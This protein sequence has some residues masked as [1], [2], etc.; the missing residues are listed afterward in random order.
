MADNSIVSAVA[1]S[2]SENPFASAWQ[3][4]T[5]VGNPH[6]VGDGTPFSIW[7]WFPEMRL[8]WDQKPTEPE[9]P[10][11]EKDEEEKLVRESE[12]GAGGGDGVGSPGLD[13]RDPEFW[14]VDALNGTKKAGGWLDVPGKTM[15]SELM[16][17]LSGFNGM[18]GGL[19]SSL[20]SGNLSTFASPGGQ[21]A[22][23]AAA[24]AFGV[25][26]AVAKNEIASA[27]GFTSGTAKTGLGST[28]LGAAAGALTGGLP[29]LLGGLLGGTTSGVSGYKGPNVMG[30]M[31]GKIAGYPNT[32]DNP[33]F[34]NIV[35]ERQT[36][37]GVMNALATPELS[38]GSWGKGT[39]GWGSPS[40][41]NDFTGMMAALGLDIT[42]D[43]TPM[44]QI[45]VQDL[46]DQYAGPKGLFDATTFNDKTK[47]LVAAIMRDRNDPMAETVAKGL[48][49][50]N[51]QAGRLAAKA[52]GGIKNI[53]ANPNL[54]DL[55]A[56][57]KA[58][59]ERGDYSG[60]A[61]NNWGEPFS[62]TPP[63]GYT[64]T[65]DNFGARAFAADIP[66]PT[67]G[68]T[69][70]SLADVFSRGLAE[71]AEREKSVGDPND[72]GGGSK[73]GNGQENESPG[74]GQS[75][76]GPGGA[77]EGASRDGR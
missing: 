1:A 2:L 57:L 44:Q 71:L 69:A 76:T 9:E 54:V 33:T 46:I 6:Y 55:Y 52:L 43:L 30:M 63:G 67:F 23:E 41:I 32:W 16:N 38:W 50:E 19:L 45:A 74:Q 62:S 4:N 3:R 58:Q 73:T 22:I 42:G 27:L 5:G 60:L 48:G 24:K 37:A 53:V 25:D 13:M 39:T 15:V 70:K 8:Q 26:P 20:F 68:S 47:G 28:A 18:R 56:E 17:M 65:L 35:N 40:S 36:I 31:A 34:S 64:G 51:Y 11:T 29:G 72:A 12:S 7:D 75:Q 21:A 59:L 66:G 14:G 77:S 49:L 10:E 61:N